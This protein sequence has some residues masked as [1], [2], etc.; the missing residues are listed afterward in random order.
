MDPNTAPDAP[1]PPRQRRPYKIRGPETWAVIRESYLAGASARVVAERYDVT[2]QAIRKRALREGWT[3][4]SRP[5]GEPP[6][7]LKPSPPLF[8]PGSDQPRRP[9][10]H[11]DY[12][13]LQIEAGDA[14]ARAMHQGRVDEALAWAR[15]ADS[16]GKI[17]ETNQRLRKDP[18]S[19]L[20]PRLS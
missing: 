7:A 2:E 11:V 19:F 18:R 6:P 13:A 10:E 4:A 14:S 15:L 20:L 12:A 9:P 1:K 5:E 3:K 16:Y 8:G 17:I